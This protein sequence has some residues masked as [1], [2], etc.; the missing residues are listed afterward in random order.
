VPFVWSECLI[1]RYFPDVGGLRDNFTVYD[2]AYIALAELL[3]VTLLM[4]D[5]CIADAPG[6][7]ARTLKAAVEMPAVPEISSDP[8]RWWCS[9]APREGP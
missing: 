6:T 1:G 7:G 8:G 2:A 5:A 4:A 3:D 9:G